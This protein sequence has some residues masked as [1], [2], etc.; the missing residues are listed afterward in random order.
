[1]VGTGNAIENHF[2]D[3]VLLA[4]AS[5][6]SD[7][8]AG[9]TSGSF[10]NGSSNQISIN[11]KINVIDFTACCKQPIVWELTR[12]FFHSDK[13]AKDGKLDQS[14]YKEYLTAYTKYIPLNEYDIS[15]LFKLYFYQLLVCD[16]YSQYFNE[17]D[18]IKKKDY[19]NQANFASKILL[20]NSDLIAQF[21]S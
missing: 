19:Y 3:P 17:T 20:A 21:T 18:A 10:S 16:Y 6:K 13:S 2:S 8:M 9:K 4:S 11:D 14:R 7:S 12:F 15:N 5:I 1:M